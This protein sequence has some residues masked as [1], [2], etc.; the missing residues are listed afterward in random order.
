MNTNFSTWLDGILENTY[1]EDVKAFNFNLYETEDE[2]KFDIQIIGS[3]VYDKNNTDWA[4]E[5]IFTSGENVFCVYAEDWITCL[6]TSSE[7]VKDYL[8]SGK[9]RNVLTKTLAVSV[10]FVDGDLSVLYERTS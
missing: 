2:H 8:K 5:E 9:F 1:F 3:P 6:E 7:L 4:C 10:G